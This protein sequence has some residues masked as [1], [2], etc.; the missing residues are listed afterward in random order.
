MFFSQFFRTFQ[1]NI[2]EARNCKWKLQ[3][4]RKNW[5]SV[6]L[7]C[8][9]VHSLLEDFFSGVNS[10]LSFALFQTNREKV[11][12]SIREEVLILL[13]GAV[14]NFVI[15]PIFLSE[16]TRETLLEIFKNNVSDSL[17]KDF[18]SNSKLQIV[19]LFIIRTVIN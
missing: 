16:A 17:P 10:T 6:S 4:G 11:R 14:Q 12:A 1:G 5:H 19:T 3:G 18:F 8:N 9:L 15:I 2:K 7:D 13:A